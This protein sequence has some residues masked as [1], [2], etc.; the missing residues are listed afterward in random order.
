MTDATDA[1]GLGR[2]GLTRFDHI[3]IAVR[4]LEP[5]VLLVRDLL[6]GE[7]IGGGD[8]AIHD[9]RTLQFKLPPGIKLELMM[10]LGDDSPLHR[11]LD[12]HGGGFHHATLFVRDVAAAADELVANGFEVVDTDLGRSSWQETYIRPRSGFGTLLQLVTSDRDWT[13]PLEPDITVEEVLAG[14]VAWIDDH[15]VRREAGAT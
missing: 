11:F 2:L 9:M 13:R 5:A 1:L 14:R 4:E 7:F 15:P 3:A 10:P 12:E 6:G 8:D